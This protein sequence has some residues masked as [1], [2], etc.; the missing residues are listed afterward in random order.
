MIEFAS[1]NQPTYIRARKFKVTTEREIRESYV[2]RYRRVL[3]AFIRNPPCL[4]DVAKV[5][6]S[7]AAFELDIA[8]PAVA[9]M[10]NSEIRA[11]PNKLGYAP[12]RKEN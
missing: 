1:L 11:N 9:A 10:S 3:E 12:T 5:V 4:E 8:T 7:A 2:L 6:A